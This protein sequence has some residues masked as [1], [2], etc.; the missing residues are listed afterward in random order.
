MYTSRFIKALGVIAAIGLVV[1]V[2][3]ATAGDMGL[4]QTLV[5]NLG[6]SEAQALG[7]S[8]A[9]LGMAK[10]NLGD[11]EF[12][13][14]TDGM[15]DLD[16]IMSGDGDGM[17]DMAASAAGAMGGSGAM[18]EMKDGAMDQM[19]EMAGEGGLGALAG[20]ADLIK[21]FTDLGMDSGMIEKFAGGLLDY[22]GGGVG[23][24][25]GPK[26]KLMRKGL[27]LL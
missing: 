16:E 25:G 9:L 4:T 3:P 14:L 2:V 1:S 23:G 19:K 17:A 8:K 5:K 21:T 13:Q 11:D 22:V 7:G 12:G 20:N 24:I 18:D 10:S 27:G 15:P 6:V 26:A